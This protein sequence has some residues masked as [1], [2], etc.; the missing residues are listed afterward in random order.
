MPGEFTIQQ[1]EKYDC[2]DWWHWAVWIEGPDDALDRIKSVEWT[3]HPTFPNPI[4]TISN[5]NSKFRLETAGWGTFPIH[6]R[7]RLEDGRELKLRHELA[8]HY[9]DGPPAPA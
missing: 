8:L 3:L 2:E 7:L 4:R 6:A 9:P 5:R 1:W